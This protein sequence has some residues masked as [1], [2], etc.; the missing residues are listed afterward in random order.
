MAPCGMM[1]TGLVDPRLIEER[2]E[3]GWYED[4]SFDEEMS[5]DEALALTRDDQRRLDEADE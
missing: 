3:R 4:V 2:W 1:W 5:V